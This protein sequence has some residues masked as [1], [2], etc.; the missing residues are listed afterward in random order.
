[1]TTIDEKLK[2]YETKNPVIALKKKLK[3]PEEF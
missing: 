1:M 2:K 3:N